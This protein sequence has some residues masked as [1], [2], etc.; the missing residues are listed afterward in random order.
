MKYDESP[1]KPRSHPVI[2]QSLYKGNG[3]NLSRRAKSC[4]VFKDP[5]PNSMKNNYFAEIN[6]LDRLL[7]LIEELSSN[8]QVVQ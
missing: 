4:Q 6:L 7:L 5:Y 3:Y 8:T 1:Q 2:E